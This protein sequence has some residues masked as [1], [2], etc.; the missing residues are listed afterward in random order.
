MIEGMASGLPMVVTDVGGNAEAV[1]DGTDGLV[2]PAQSPGALGAAILR[3]VLDGHLRLSMG[4]SARRRA[5][6]AFGLEANVASYAR[7]YE[8][9]LRGVPAAEIVESLPEIPLAE[10]ALHGAS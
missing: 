8:A 5:Q 1:R 9:I 2:V 10:R 7:I 3:L 6:A 4:Q